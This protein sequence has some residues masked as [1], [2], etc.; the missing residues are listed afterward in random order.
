MIGFGLMAVSM[1]TETDEEDLTEQE[2][3]H[4]HGDLQVEDKLQQE[5]PKADLLDTGAS[6]EITDATISIDVGDDETGRI[7][8]VRSASEIVLSPG[9]NSGGIDYDI[10]FYLVPEGVDFPP[11]PSEIIEE[12]PELDEYNVGKLDFF[13]Y[14][15]NIGLKPISTIDLGEFRSVSSDDVSDDQTVQDTRI[16]GLEIISNQEVELIGFN[17]SD[18][19]FIGDDDFV[20][21]DDVASLATNWEDDWPESEIQNGFDGEVLDARSRES[22]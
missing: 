21:L 10:N 5:E 3:V 20:V 14:F 17:T 2:D 4:D 18:S 13:D 6:V 16:S 7:V 9:G 19:G 12:N 22:K 15:D 11:T 1:G 8:G